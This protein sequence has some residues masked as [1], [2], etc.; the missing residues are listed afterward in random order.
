MLYSFKYL[1][2]ECVMPH[3]YEL[4]ILID[5]CTQTG[6]QPFKCKLYGTAFTE[7][8]YQKKPMQTHT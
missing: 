2:T 6:E 8:D 5:I 7:S 4:F 3:S 1:N